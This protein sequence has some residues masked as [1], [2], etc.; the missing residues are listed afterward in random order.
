MAIVGSVAADITGLSALIGMTGIAVIGLV[1]SLVVNLVVNL[2]VS[3]II[4]LIMSAVTR[5]F[6]TEL[7]L[8]LIIGLV[9][10]IVHICLL[11][12]VS[13]C[14]LILPLCRKNIAKI[15]GCRKKANAKE[16]H[17]QIYLKIFS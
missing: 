5:G 13:I 11:I 6:L 2:A 9:S 16:S 17:Y 15:G 14:K 8:I 7:L 12:A 4:N 10:E 3:L 1:M